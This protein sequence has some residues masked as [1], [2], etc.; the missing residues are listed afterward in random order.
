[1]AQVGIRITAQDDTSGAFGSVNRGLETIKGNAATV[2]NAL[3]G[4]GIGLSAGA[5]V[6]WTQN[7]INSIDALNDLKDAT[8]ASIENISALE[9]IA[10]RTG[11]SFDTVSTS[12]V[13]LN[14]GLSAAKPGSD[15]AIAIE[16]IGLSV[17]DLKSLDP[18][19]AFRQIAVG[20]NGFSDDANKARIVQEIF[21]KSLKEVAPLLKDVAEAGSLNATVTTAQAEAAEKFNKQIFALQGSIQ[22]ASRAL[23]S[24]FLPALNQGIDRLQIAY[25]HAGSLAGVLA[26]Y[27]RIDASAGFSGNIATA[28]NQIKALEERASRITSDSAR[29]GNQ[30]AIDGLK[31]QIAY[32]KELQRVK[33]LD[34]TDTQSNAEARRLGVSTSSR[35]LADVEA[36]KTRQKGIE[37]ANKLA[38]KA[39]EQYR[40]ELEAQSKLLDNLS[41]Y[42]SN[43]AEEINLVAKAYAGG[44]MTLEQMQTAQQLIFE[45]QPVA[46]KFAKEQEDIAKALSK[47]YQVEQ[48]AY[49][50][51]LKAIVDGADS[52][53]KHLQ[54]LQ[55]EEKAAGLAVTQNI[56]LA[57]AIERVSLARSRET[58]EK[59]AAAGA[60]GQTLL[61][62]QR[63]VQ[64]RE[65]LVAAVSSKES[66]DA[67]SKSASDAAKEWAKTAEKI[68]DAITDALMRAFESG[69]DFFVSIRDTIVNTFKTMVIRI[70][71]Q[72]AVEGAL[73]A[74]GLG[75]ATSSIAGAA[76]G[77]AAGSSLWGAGAAAAGGTTI[78]GGTLQLST[79]A[80]ETLASIETALAAVPGWGWA[81]LAAGALIFGSSR[82]GTATANTG[83]ARRT[84]DA[85][86]NLTGESTQFG[87]T[88]AANDAIDSVQKAYSQAVRALGATASAAQ[89]GYGSNN[90]DGGK[91]IVTADVGGRSYNSNEVRPD[92][93]A[94][95]A[96]RAVLTALQG[97]DLPK[98]MSQVFNNLNVNEASQEAISAAVQYAGSLKTLRESM[99]GIG[100]YTDILQT[101][102]NEGF[103]TLGTSAAKFKTDFVAALDGG[104]TKEQLATWQKLAG[105]MNALAEAT[106]DYSLVVR[107]QTDILKERQGL[108]AQL[109]ELTQTS[110]QALQAQRDALDESN[111]SLFDQVQLAKSAKTASEDAAKA[112]KQAAADFAAAISGA[113]SSIESA[114]SRLTSAQANV[115]AIRAEA[116]SNYLA[117][118][119]EVSDAQ[120]R[121]TAAQLG[122]QN[123]LARAASE[124]AREMGDLGRKLRE[125]VDGAT[126][127]PRQSFA[128]LLAAALGGD[129][130]A[131]QALPGAA[132]GAIQG[133]RQTAGS[134]SDFAIQQA[135]IIAQ[136]SAVAGIAELAGSVLAPTTVEDAVVVA[137][138]E[139]TAAQTRLT[140]A[141]TAANSIGAPLTSQISD[142][143]GR[144]ASAQSE[145]TAAFNNL[146]AEIR[147]SLATIRV[148]AA[149][150]TLAGG[151]TYTAAEVASAATGALQSGASAGQVFSDASTKFGISAS[152]LASV[153]SV[154]G[155]TA[156]T[157][158][159]KRIDQ[160][161]TAS[162]SDIAAVVA[163]AARRALAAG[164]TPQAEFVKHL[165][166]IGWNAGM[167]DKY[168]GWSQGTTN[169]WAVANGF[170]AFARGVNYLPSDMLAQVHE[171]ERIIPAADNRELMNR[172]RQPQQNGEALVEEIRSLREENRSQAS[173]I[174]GLQSRMTKLFERWDGTGIPETRVT[175]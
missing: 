81:A 22:Q 15:V 57:E 160:T 95:V 16:A 85:S 143:V 28:E 71:V 26:M 118:L 161:A 125:F 158:Y 103:S 91:V 52:V 102:V 137:Q 80:M 32:V 73:G 79:G 55:D 115:D 62:L 31:Q 121:L 98:Y 33:A 106:G 46:K 146:A 41:G 113:L 44:S 56:S 100:D 150:G 45:Q 138:R 108:Q 144:Y 133:A 49:E 159:Q 152:D 107:S 4:L 53:E 129:R 2:N 47:A 97:S 69:K 29:R 70:P 169:A 74:V 7:I 51:Q 14:Q 142:L 36:Q 173:A 175:A 8:G 94:L 67:V 24:D 27:S 109:D 157:D 130:T 68:N 87:I 140:A 13:K 164:T 19:E 30:A 123:E 23:V 119:E 6:A 84:F 48:K 105:D 50:D 166:S 83:D 61:A 20:L 163:E 167:G 154:A 40:R 111:K 25:K 147:Q 170:P 37:D 171:G 38:A 116:T 77:S 96:S 88:A 54:R 89:F 112:A 12:L 148:S 134:A 78:A 18:A 141:L 122:A 11:A 58:Y 17:K 114:R 59:A 162:Q 76:A 63:E 60:D 172:L 35:S 43:Y 131:M 3:A 149:G 153:A 42:N 66:R 126:L 132:T 65:K 90:I 156:L 104:L 5:F 155:I 101:K 124:A 86:G 92:Q 120:G 151:K 1:M 93:L 34:D 110:V 75:A 127:S 139:L 82:Q 168:M 39:A 145:L 174:V 21:G 64:A 128:K 9:D 72:Y 165:Q 136:V 10:K 135:R 99:L 117:A